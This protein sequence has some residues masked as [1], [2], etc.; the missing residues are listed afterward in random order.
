[1]YLPKELLKVL[2]CPLTKSAL[3]YD[4]ENNEL[5]SPKAMLAFRVE[6]GV[7]ML[8][9]EEAHKVSYERIQKALKAEENQNFCKSSADLEKESV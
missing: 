5:I 6:D 8:L 2:V 4:R 1:M 7:P 9:V 3:I